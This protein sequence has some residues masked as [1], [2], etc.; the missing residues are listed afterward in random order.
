MDRQ[1]Q[2]IAVNR[3]IALHLYRLMKKSGTLTTIVVAGV[4]LCLL[5]GYFFTRV[6]LKDASGVFEISVTQGRINGAPIRDPEHTFDDSIAKIQNFTSQKLTAILNQTTSSFR[7]LDYELTN[8]TPSFRD[9]LDVNFDKYEVRERLS[10]EKTVYS[11]TFDMVDVPIVVNATTPDKRQL[12]DIPYE[13]LNTTIFESF[14]LDI[15]ANF[16]LTDN[17]NKM[18]TK[19]KIEFYVDASP[20]DKD[21]YQL[22][23]MTLWK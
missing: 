2:E 12:S 3:S 20:A 6:Q 7:Y 1:S 16:E 13:Q 11:M 19:H 8:T 15:T 18:R 23:G 22:V 4:T 17:R 10:N 9:D 5:V 21:Q 14:R